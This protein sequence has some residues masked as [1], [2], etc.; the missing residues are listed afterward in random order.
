M[1]DDARVR[2]LMLVNLFAVFSDAIPG[3]ASR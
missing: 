3:V 1:T 2:E